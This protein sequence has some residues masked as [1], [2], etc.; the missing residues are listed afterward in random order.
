MRVIYHKIENGHEKPT[1]L[2]TFSVGTNRTTAVDG[3]EEKV[4]EA[5]DLLRRSSTPVV[6][7]DE[8]IPFRICQYHGENWP[9]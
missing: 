7:P 3:E 1:L 4:C 2:H 9:H 5:F 8:L 6:F